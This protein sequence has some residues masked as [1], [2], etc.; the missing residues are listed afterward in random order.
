MPRGLF[1]KKG[2]FSEEGLDRQLQDLEQDVDDSLRALSTELDGVKATTKTTLEKNEADIKETSEVA[3][4]TSSDT[5]ALDARVTQNESNIAS[6]I[7]SVFGRLLFTQVGTTNG[8]RFPL[9][10]IV[11]DGISESGDIIT[12]DRGGVYHFDLMMHAGSTV[13]TNPEY[14]VL[15]MRIN[16]S[17]VLEPI[18]LRFSSSSGDIIPVRGMYVGRFSQGDTVDFISGTTGATV[19]PQTFNNRSTISVHRVGP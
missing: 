19:T 5:S 6:V 2:Y 12:I 8:N 13:T 15:Q 1:R 10:Q 17:I 11:L 7:P 18:S 16:G 14:I 9:T 4:R 3:N